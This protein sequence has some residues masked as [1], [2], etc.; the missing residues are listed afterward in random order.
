MQRIRKTKLVDAIFLVQF[1]TQY[2]LASTFVRFQEY[3]ES[4]RFGGRTFSLEEFMDWYA[5]KFGAFTYFEDWSGFNVPSTVF[6]PFLAGRFDPLLEKEKQ[7]LRLFARER[8]P[9][10]VIGLPESSPHQDL[11]HELAHAMFFTRPAYKTA[12][13]KAMRGW[14]T[15]PIERELREMGYHRKVLKDEVH[16]YLVSGDASLRSPTNRRF[17]PLRKTLRA[18]FRMHRAKLRLTRLN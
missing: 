18:L 3:F 10:Y 12:V 7:F 9:F 6:A 1:K 4:S 17:Q 14:N 2:E 11:T 8:S 16:A 15:Q 13:L 5:S